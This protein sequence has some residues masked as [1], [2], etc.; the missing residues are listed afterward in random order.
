VFEIIIA[1]KEKDGNKNYAQTL[2]SVCKIKICIL[3][4]SGNLL[5][6]FCDHWWIK[7]SST[8]I[9][10]ILWKSTSLIFSS[11]SMFKTAFTAHTSIWL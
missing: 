8:I 7:R 3:R 9:S 5:L 2:E 1:R 6:N 10:R 4:N 11:L